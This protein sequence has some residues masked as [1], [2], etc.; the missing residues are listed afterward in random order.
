MCHMLPLLV[1]CINTIIAMRTRYA[2][3]HVITTSSTIKFLGMC[4]SFK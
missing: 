2:V 4:V 1:G 3:P